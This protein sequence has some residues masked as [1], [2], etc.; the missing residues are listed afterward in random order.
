M[1]NFE[2]LEFYKKARE[3]ARVLDDIIL[4]F[5]KFEIYAL[6]DQMRRAADSVVSN[7]AEGGSK[8]T[9]AD[10]T[11]YLRHALGSSQELRVQVERA[12]EKSYLVVE[13]RDRL[14]DELDRIG[15]MINGFIRKLKEN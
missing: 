6:G 10:M 7:I 2:R 11:N 15:R 13:D 5:P 14:I 3:V 8:K 1:Y 9:V 4:G 12:F